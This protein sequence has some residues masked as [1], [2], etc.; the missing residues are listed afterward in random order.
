MNESSKISIKFVSLGCPK[1]LVDSE[2]MAGLLGKDNFVVL[3]S[4]QKTDVAIINTCGFI[5]DSKQESINTILEFASKKEEGE[6]KLLIV[7]GCLSQRYA[8]QLPEALPEVDAFMGTG[9]FFKLPQIIRE[10][11]DGDQRSNFIQT[12]QD[13]ISWSTPRVQTTP[14]YTRYVKISEGC[15]HSCSFCTIPMMRGGLRSRTVEDIKKEIEIGVENGVKEFNLIA[16]D[17]NEYGRDLDPR[18]SLFHLFEE[19][20]SILGDFWLRPLYMYPLQFPDRLVR[21]MA[22]HPHLIPYVDIPLQHIDDDILKSMNRGSSSKYIYR[23]IENLRKNI[24]GIILRTTFIV[25]YP[26]ETEEKF[27]KLLNFIKEIEFDHLGVFTYSHEEGTP[28]F[29]IENQIDDEIKKERQARLMEIQHEISKKKNQK[30]LNQ[31]LE[32][33]FE[34]DLPEE[35]E[36]DFELPENFI[37]IGR[38]YGQAPSIDGLTFIT[39]K[40]KEIPH[41]G[42][43]IKVKIHQTHAYDLVGEIS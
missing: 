7:S 24:P 6:L 35:I 37:G 15:S 4:D 39:S 2:V 31:E 10:K 11:L 1:N 22:D 16:Q 29:E 32:V 18:E 19:L 3:P 41:L 36:L 14:D 13:Q 26:T 30:Y 34:G 5:E 21:L 38:F 8:K 28:A 23:L 27:E 17:L 33:I 43:K 12:P 40:N 25:G 20:G 9:D 42:S